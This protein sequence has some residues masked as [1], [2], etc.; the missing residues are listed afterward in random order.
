MA[1]TLSHLPCESTTPTP[2]T[3]SHPISIMQLEWRRGGWRDCSITLGELTLLV[4]DALRYLYATIVHSLI[5]YSS[6]LSRVYAEPPLSASRY[7]VR[8]TDQCSLP[9]LEVVAGTYS[10]TR[11][12]WLYIEA[13]GWVSSALSRGL[14]WRR[15][16]LHTPSDLIHA[17]TTPLAVSPHCTLLSHHPTAASAPSSSTVHPKPTQCRWWVPCLPALHTRA[18]STH[19]LCCWT[20][21]TP[22]H[23]TKTSTWHCRGSTL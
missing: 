16:L 8:C 2:C 17:Q 5:P 4:S 11:A 6:S 23:S 20:V 7:R 13:A 15:M 9:L 3:P 19:D 22:S 12:R 18:D 10:N 21:A 1:G 14:R